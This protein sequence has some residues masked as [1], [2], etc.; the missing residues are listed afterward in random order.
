MG[1]LSL[2]EI[3]QAWDV[4]AAATNEMPLNED[5]NPGGEPGELGRGNDPPNPQPG[6]G[7]GKPRLGVR[8]AA[9]V[10]DRMHGIRVCT[11]PTDVLCTE[12]ADF[13]PAVYLLRDNV[14]CHRMGA[15]PPIAGPACVGWGA[16]TRGADTLTIENSEDLFPWR[17]PG[18]EPTDQRLPSMYRYPPP[19]SRASWNRSSSTQMGSGYPMYLGEHYLG[20]EQPLEGDVNKYRDRDSLQ[21]KEAD[22]APGMYHSTDPIAPTSTTMTAHDRMLEE[23]SQLLVDGALGAAPS[24]EQL[25]RH[26][27]HCDAVPPTSNDRQMAW[28]RLCCCYDKD[29]LEDPNAVC[30]FIVCGPGNFSSGEHTCQSCPPNTFSDS[31]KG[32]IECVNSS[33]CAAGRF[34]NS[35]LRACQDCPV[36]TFSTDGTMCRACPMGSIASEG[37]HGCNASNVGPGWVLAQPMDSCSTTCARWG[38]T[39]E[40]GEEW[41]ADSVTCDESVLQSLDFDDIELIGRILHSIVVADGSSK[42]QRPALPRK[43]GPYS[44]TQVSRAKLNDIL[45][46]SDSLTSK[47]SMFSDGTYEGAAWCSRA[48]SRAFA[49]N[50][51][52]IFAISRALSHTLRATSLHPSPSLRIGRHH[53]RCRRRAPR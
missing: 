19:P 41:Q 31:P 14:R 37:S 6:D 8:H 3:E 45:K 22:A 40:A 33:G 38:N 52:L 7:R 36:N 32:S 50:L 35:T 9:Q 44:E 51:A 11:D 24:A 23:N 43:G 1:A 16:S 18:F 28:S 49:R 29:A 25:R 30:P 26:A 48:C 47:P 2:S 46:A 12:W 39:E 53:Q 15:D 34:A 4:N 5:G 20:K 27:A 17:R 21:R 13:L 10:T 42:G